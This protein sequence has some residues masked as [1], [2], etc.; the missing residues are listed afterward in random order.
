MNLRR[1]F[2]LIFFYEIILINF[3]NFVKIWL[4]SKLRNSV[5]I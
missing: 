4:E 2:E 3:V 5:D 1:I